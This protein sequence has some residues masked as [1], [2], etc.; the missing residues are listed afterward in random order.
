MRWAWDERETNSPLGYLNLGY[1]IPAS[2]LAR[3]EVVLELG[4][5]PSHVAIRGEE[6]RRISLH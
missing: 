1:G 4:N 6:D 2:Y 5:F 3:G